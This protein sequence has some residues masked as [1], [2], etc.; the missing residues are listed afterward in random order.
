MRSLLHILGSGEPIEEPG[1][2]KEMSIERK[3]PNESFE[4]FIFQIQSP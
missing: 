4:Q 2:P 3:Q 1:W